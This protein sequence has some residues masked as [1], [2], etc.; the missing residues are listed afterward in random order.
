M[1]FTSYIVDNDRTF[2]AAIDRARNVTDDLRIPLTLISKDFYKSEK[3]I[4]QLSGPGK[5]PDLADSTKRQKQK[6][7][8]SVYPILKRTGRLEKSLTKPRSSDSINEIINKKVL[9]IGSK[10]PYLI[11]HQSDK[12]RKKI[13]LR[14]ALF[15]GPE[16]PTF[17]TSDQMGRTERW[18]NIMNEFVLEKLKVELE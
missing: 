6:A 14:K 7:G 11:F 9:I 12:P 3:A 5:Y 4:F 1:A 15:I 17:A 10:T 8:F 16:A 2:Q 13:P 18:L